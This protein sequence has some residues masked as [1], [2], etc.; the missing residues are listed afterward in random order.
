MKRV[1]GVV[2]LLLMTIAALDCFVRGASLGLDG[3][4]LA[5]VASSVP[6]AL[7]ASVVFMAGD[8]YWAVCVPAFVWGAACT[9]MELLFRCWFPDREFVGEQLMVSVV[10]LSGE[11]VM[12]FIAGNAT[13]LDWTLFAAAVVAVLVAVA[14]MTSRTI[15]APT[16]RSFIGGFALAAAM[17]CV[18][19]QAMSHDH[20]TMAFLD[21]EFLRCRDR[22]AMYGELR[23]G[24]E[25][26]TPG[27]YSSSESNLLAVVVIG[28]SATRGHLSLYGYSRKTTP[29]IDAV[30]DELLVFSNV[31]A[32]VAFTPFALRDLFTATEG[33]R[34]VS[35]PSA[36]VSAGFEAS[37]CSGQARSGI[38]DGA[39]ELL[40]AACATRRYLCDLLSEGS[41]HDGALVPLV[42]ED[43][44]SDAAKRLVFVHLLGSHTSWCNNYPPEFAVFSGGYVDAEVEGLPEAAVMS[45]NTYDNSILYTDH[46]VGELLDSVKASGRPAVLVYVSDHGESP[47]SSVE[48][49]H[50]HPD[51]HAIPCFIWFSEEYRRTHAGLIDRLAEMRSLPLT[52]RDLFRA[53]MDLLGLRAAVVDS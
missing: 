33:G 28:E 35:V 26:L 16:S 45:V 25:P 1:F 20:L 15:G 9:G 50:R 46:V 18:M 23:E 5:I 34:V 42:R 21:H 48:R 7:L 32:E 44:A 13:A 4:L 43:A 49:D 52:S 37:L 22:L 53:W 2:F 27:A 6:S 40:F 14:W 8:L 47:C 24:G 29:R 38:Y 36:A 17:I 31:T 10:T 3:W 19:P 11:K 30:A 12:A 41:Y 39:D 51:S